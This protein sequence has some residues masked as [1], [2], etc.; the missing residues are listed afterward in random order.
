MKPLLIGCLLST[1]SV[2]YCSAYKVGADPCFSFSEPNDQ[3]SQD[4]KEF[5]NALFRNAS[6][7]HPEVGINTTLDPYPLP[8]A[9]PY[10]MHLFGIDVPVLITEASLTGFATASV[11]VL[12]I[13]GEGDSR[14]AHLELDV[15]QAFME[16]KFR[17]ES[18]LDIPGVFNATAPNIHLLLVGTITANDTSTN[19]DPETVEV[20]YDGTL[21]LNLDPPIPLTE[22]QIQDLIND[23][24]K[25]KLVEVI[26]IIVDHVLK[27]TCPEI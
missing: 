4:V 11:P 5:I 20:S 21:V 27:P 6:L 8:T 22:Q 26:K 13:S 17:I 2:V 3:L 18:P 7:P 1:F 16:G 15:K 12:N 23:L 19:V 25:D 24:A 9:G 14:Y 10:T